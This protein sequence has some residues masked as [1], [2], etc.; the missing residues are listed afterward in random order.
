MTVFVGVATGNMKAQLAAIVIGII[1]F[2][3]SIPI[4]TAIDANIGVRAVTLAILELISV[5]KTMSV[6]IA[7][8]MTA[9]GYCA[10]PD[11]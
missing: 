8:I 5:K 1:S 11:S 10:S 9:S 3:G 4:L 2:T 7:R 6:T